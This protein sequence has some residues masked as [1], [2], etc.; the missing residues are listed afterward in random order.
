MSKKIVVVSL[1]GVLVSRR[2]WD[3]AHRIGMREHEEIV[4]RKFEGGNYWDFVRESLEKSG[5]SVG[6]RRGI[7]MTRVLEGL[8][9]SDVNRDVVEF[10]KGVKGKYKLVLLTTNTRAVTGEILKRMGC[11]G[12]FDDVFSSETEEADDKSTVLRRMLKDVGKVDCLVEEGGK[13]ENFCEEGRIG[14]LRFG[15]LDGLR[16]F[17]DKFK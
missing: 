16:G 12:L 8:K 17:L 11:E 13:L 15:D 7:Y 9:D 6:E 1:A 2:P 14:Y 4:G 10:L 3:E 5:M